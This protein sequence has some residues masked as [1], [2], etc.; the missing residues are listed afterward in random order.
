[1]PNPDVTADVVGLGNAIVDV[2]AEA[3]EALVG[4]L[5]LD[6]GTMTLVDEAR[7]VSLYDAMG[8]AIEIS[9]GSCANSMAALAGLGAQATYVGKVRNDQ[10]GEVFR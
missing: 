5:G 10:L 3:E 2:V 8:P 9:G 4:R 6:R 1:M 7:M